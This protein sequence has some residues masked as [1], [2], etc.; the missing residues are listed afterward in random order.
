MNAGGVRGE[1]VIEPWAWE[2]TALT[3]KVR[4]TLGNRLLAEVNGDTDARR[5]LCAALEIARDA[6]REIQL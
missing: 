6:C 1:I 2:A 5:A 3:Y 4:V